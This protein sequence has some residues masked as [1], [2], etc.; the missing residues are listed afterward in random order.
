MGARGPLWV[1]WRR[2]WLICLL[3]S[4]YWNYQPLTA[5][6]R[7]PAVVVSRMTELTIQ[8]SLRGL[9]CKFWIMYHCLKFDSLHPSIRGFLIL[10]AQSK[11]SPCFLVFGH[12]HY[13]APLAW[14]LVY[15]YALCLHK[16]IPFLEIQLLVY[17]AVAAA[18]E[19]LW[20]WGPMKSMEVHTYKPVSR[21]FTILLFPFC[22][23]FS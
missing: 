16:F 2:W 20:K 17:T 14:K 12:E 15:Q 7:W 8:L 1:D 23:L 11:I 5:P 22:L 6:S 19:A 18:N 9:V 4:D 10:C 13:S 3:Y 21:F